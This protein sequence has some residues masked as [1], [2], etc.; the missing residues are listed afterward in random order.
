MILNLVLAIYF[1]Y[2]CFKGVKLARQRIGLFA[3]I[4]L[5]IILISFISKPHGKD[6]KEKI[7][8]DSVVRDDS[9]IYREKGSKD[10]MLANNL[11]FSNK[12]RI[13]YAV[14]NGIKRPYKAICMFS[15]IKGYYDWYPALIFIQDSEGNIDN[16]FKYTI[17]TTTI[18]RL[19][20]IDFFATSKEYE[21][22]F[23]LD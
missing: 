5:A 7:M 13:Y 10:I 6:K 9:L 23:S 3:P 17:N 4:F 1:L 18:F 19:L 2:L 15:G 21:G 20:F 12:L 11:M 8:W 22:Q 16:I 14:Q